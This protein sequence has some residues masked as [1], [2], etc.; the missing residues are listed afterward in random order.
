[1]VVK[2]SIFHN[3]DYQAVTS[4]WFNSLNYSELVKVCLGLM[5][6]LGCCEN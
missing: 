4:V 6:I 5:K 2:M 3:A 1:M